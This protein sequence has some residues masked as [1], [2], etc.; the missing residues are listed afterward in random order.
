VI[1]IAGEILWCILFHISSA[2]PVPNPRAGV[3][4]IDKEDEMSQKTFWRGVLVGLVCLALATFAHAQA[5][6]GKPLIS[7][8]G[9]NT[10]VAG[11]AAAG[12]AGVVS[13][14]T[15]VMTHKKEITGCVTALT[16]GMSLTDEH[17]KQTYE[18]M[19]S[20]TDFRAGDRV[21]I[22]VKRIKSTDKGSAPVWRVVKLI[23]NYG[24]C[25]E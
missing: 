21:R 1:G 20:T 12:A 16:E 4:F 24:S 6:S 17:D 14:I 11:G 13:L 15:V 23:K 22:Q 7:Y 5:G 18:L 19:G 9:S 3:E 2:V 8:K 25:E 10:A